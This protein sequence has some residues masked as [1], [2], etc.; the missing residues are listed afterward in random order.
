[1][2]PLVFLTEVLE[3]ANADVIAG[4]ILSVSVDLY[5]PLVS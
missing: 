5:G 2:L 1:M 3:E 4:Y